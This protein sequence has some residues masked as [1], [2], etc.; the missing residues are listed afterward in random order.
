[1]KNYKYSIEGMYTEVFMAIRLSEQDKRQHTNEKKQQE[2]LH[3]HKE[4]IKNP[5]K[6]YNANIENYSSESFK[7][8]QKRGRR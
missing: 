7:A 6:K 4:N 5:V 3:L 2:A 8:M 1:M